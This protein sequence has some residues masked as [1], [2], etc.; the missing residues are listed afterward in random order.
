MEQEEEE[1]GETLSILGELLQTLP[2]ILAGAKDK[3][4]RPKPLLG[5]AV[6]QPRIVLAANAKP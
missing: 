4:S 2:F 1:E 6:F 3:P 5:V